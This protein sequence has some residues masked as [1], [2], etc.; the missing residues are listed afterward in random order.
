[1]SNV[2]SSKPDEVI[3]MMR[4]SAGSAPRVLTAAIASPALVLI[5]SAASA[6]EIRLTRPVPSG[7]ES[8]LVDERAWNAKC[9][10]LGASITI[11]S[12]PIN[13]KVTIVPGVSIVPVGTQSGNVGRCAG[14]SI[15]GNQIMYKS[16]AGFR[17]IDTLAYEVRYGNGKSAS[18]IITINVR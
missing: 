6:Q 7:A 18:T 12:Q 5:A 8:V 9:K 16:N 3:A 13:G 17:G 11:T 10:P 1:M 14:K 2:L 4:I 15:S